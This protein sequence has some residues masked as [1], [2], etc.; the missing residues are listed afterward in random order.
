[1]IYIFSKHS[2]TT[3]LFSVNQPGAAQ[4]AETQSLTKQ[5]PSNYPCNNKQIKIS[6]PIL[7][8]ISWL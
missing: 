5:P 6:S 8:I 7:M 3:K 2:L 1:M 4:E